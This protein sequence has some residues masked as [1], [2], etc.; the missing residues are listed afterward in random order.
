MSFA[1]LSFPAALTRF[2]TCLVLNY[3]YNWRGY[4]ANIV[5]DRTRSLRKYEGMDGSPGFPGMDVTTEAAPNDFDPDS[6]FL[7]WKPASVLRSEPDDMACGSIPDR[8]DFQFALAANRKR[9]ESIQG[10]WASIFL[11]VCRLVFQYSFS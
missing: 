1:T 2:V 4:Y 8:P 3:G 7:F 10:R 9:K 5:L 11:S 6:H